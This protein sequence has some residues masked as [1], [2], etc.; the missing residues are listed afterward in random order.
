MPAY[1][2]AVATKVALAASACSLCVISVVALK[3]LSRLDAVAKEQRGLR[4]Q[5]ANLLSML[6]KAGFKRGKTVDWSD[7]L[8]ETRLLED[9][10]QSSDTK[11]FWRK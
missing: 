9:A 10:L 8:Q 2:W 6:L 3:M 1:F 4:Q 7:D 5:M 11:W